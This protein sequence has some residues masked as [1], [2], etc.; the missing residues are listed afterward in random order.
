MASASRRSHFPARDLGPLPVDAINAVLGT[1]L[2]PG[3][4]RLSEAA[5]RHM[6]ED[7]PDDYAT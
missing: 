2:E 1:E 7:H 3:N 4:V 5:H 6:A